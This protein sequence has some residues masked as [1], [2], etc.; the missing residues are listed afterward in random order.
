MNNIYEQHDATFWGVSAWV[1]MDGARKVAVISSKTSGAVTAYV[2][3]FGS[4]MK[5]GRALG[6][7][8]DM[9]SAAIAAAAHRID[10][11]DDRGEELRGI[12]SRDDGGSWDVAAAEAGFTVLRA[13]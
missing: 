3:L 5:K 6:G 7:G 4:E 8:Y 12:L 11:P 1:I 9:T 13:L 2:H 10:A